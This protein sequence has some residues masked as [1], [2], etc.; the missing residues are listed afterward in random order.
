VM[1][2]QSIERPPQQS[3]RYRADDTFRLPESRPNACR[4]SSQAG[5]REPEKRTT[6]KYQ[7]VELRHR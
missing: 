5:Y 1:S 6:G 7:D 2:L 3:R 4:R